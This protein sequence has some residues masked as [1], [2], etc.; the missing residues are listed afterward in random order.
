M[1]PS[2]EPGNRYLFLDF[3]RALAAWL[4]VWDHLANNMLREQG[5]TF[6]PAKWVHDNITAP[7]GIIQDFGWFG[8]ALFFLISG[9]IISDRARVEGVLEF[10]IKRVLR[11]Y[12]MLAVAVLLS[13]V[14]LAGDADLTP[15]TIILNLTLANYLVIP[16]I[17]LVGAAWTLVIEMIF[18]ALTASTQFMR[19]SPHR[20]AFNLAFV[21]LLVWKRGDFGANFALFAAAA[22]YLPILVMGQTI[23][24]WLA[25]NRLS[26]FWGFAYLLAAYGVFVWGLKESQPGFLLVT[27]SYVISVAYALL[28]FVALLRADLPQW[29]WVRFL[30]DTSYSVYLLQ[31]SIGWLVLMAMIKRAPLSVS[32]PVAAGATLLAAFVTHKLVEQPT[33][34]LGRHLTRNLRAWPAT[35]IRPMKSAEESA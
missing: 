18:Y 33:Q 21:A 26:A 6:L 35:A 13:C 14:F 12:P 25:R 16:Q 10:A 19:G 20:I 32:I 24:W 8:V 4:V 5:R 27:N 31:G 9:F 30:S 22:S 3:L 11:I 17:A 28:L 29:R 1:T 2:Q 23:Y 34:R 15:R 7:L